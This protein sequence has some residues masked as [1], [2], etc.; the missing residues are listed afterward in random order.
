MKHTPAR[1]SRTN[2]IGKVKLIVEEFEKNV[3]VRDANT[4][5]CETPEMKYK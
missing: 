1:N 3:Q 2:E 4:N 5:V